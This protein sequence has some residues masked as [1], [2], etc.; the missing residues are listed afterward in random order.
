MGLLILNG[1]PYTLTT[2]TPGVAFPLIPG[3][4][5]TLPP[6]AP[7]ILKQKDG[8]RA[9]LENDF[10]PSNIS[11]TLSQIAAP[12]YIAPPYTVLPGFLKLNRVVGKVPTSVNAKVDGQRPVI[13]PLSGQITLVLEYFVAG[14]ATMT[15]PGGPEF[16]P[17]RTHLLK[18]TLSGQ[19]GLECT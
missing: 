5:L 13:T 14:G 18:L 2:L 8:M 4:T 11:T 6:K 3:G 12:A 10:S 9:A 15:T 19:P 7:A 16:E 1:A 17:P